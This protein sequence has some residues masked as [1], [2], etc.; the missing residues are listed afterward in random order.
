MKTNK[1]FMES[2]GRPEP[3]A[4]ENSSHQK[5]FFKSIHTTFQRAVESTGGSSNFVLRIGEEIIRLQFAGP[6]LRPVLL[7]ALKHLLVEA[8]GTSPAL[9]VYLWDSASTGVRMPPPA[10]SVEDY[11]TRGEVRGFNDGRLLAAFQADAGVLSLLDKKR[12]QAIYWAKDP[13][14]IS[15]AERAAPLRIILGWWMSYRGCLSVHAG[16]VGN[17]SGGVLI[18]GKGGAGKSSTALSC[19]LSPLGYAGDDYCL[20]APAPHPTVFSLYCSA[21]IHAFDLPKFPFLEP[22]VSNRHQL[23]KEKAVCFLCEAH[24]DKLRLRF[25]LRAVLI[26]QVTGE[27]ETRVL[28]APPAAGLKALAPTSIAQIPGAGGEVIQRIAAV[29]R[30]VPCFYLNLGTEMS[31]IPD[32][33]ARLLMSL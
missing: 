3:V 1:A 28:P 27:R 15:V 22:L 30:K 10:W 18:V 26:P 31:Q 33:I 17:S 2:F 20:L 25:P 6:A 14:G 21:K 24:P 11:M 19:F 13:D 32:A 8:P 16:A 29:V 9:T 5:E 4:Q 12:A 7:P 23:D